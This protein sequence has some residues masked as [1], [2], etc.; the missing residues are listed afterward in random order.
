MI[1]ALLAA[2]HIYVTLGRLLLLLPATEKTCAVQQVRF[3][4]KDRSWERGANPPGGDCQFQQFVEP[5][6]QE[7]LWADPGSDTRADLEVVYKVTGEAQPKLVTLKEEALEPGSQTHLSAHGRKVKSRVRVEVKNTGDTAVLAGDVI[8]SLSK[9]HDSCLGNGP[10][11]AIPP[12][13]TLVDL[14]PGLLSPSMKAWVAVFT[15]DTACRWV[16]V[17]MHH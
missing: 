17:P 6:A 1:I 9:P 5:G 12:G 13:E 7:P 14:R 3:G 8:A 10:T 11:A 2:G 15:T 16:E 4:P